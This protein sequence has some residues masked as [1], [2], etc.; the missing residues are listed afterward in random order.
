MN[1]D[2]GTKEVVAIFLGARIP[3]QH[4][5]N[6]LKLLY[7][8]NADGFE[9]APHYNEAPTLAAL[10]AAVAGSAPLPLPDHSKAGGRG[11][12]KAGTFTD[13]LYN[14]I[15]KKPKSRAALKALALKGGQWPVKSLDARLFQLHRRG[16][17]TKLP[18]GSYV[19][20]KTSVPTATDQRMARKSPSQPRTN[21]KSI[22]SLILARVKRAHPKPVA[23]S[24]LRDLLAKRGLRAA[25]AS[26]AI[27][28][29]LQR[30]LVTRAGPAS[31][32]YQPPK[33][34]TMIREPI[35]ADAAII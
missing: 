9:I 22:A 34:D 8:V 31:Y 13:F 19:V 28:W 35:D 4:V 21:P 25:S 27:N 3:I 18:D 5:G 12:S 30:G 15:R 32:I 2:H 29:W 14:Q 7:S 16:D 17:I 33:A 11:K 10:A 20:G 26:V 23:L 6:V 24:A 1:V